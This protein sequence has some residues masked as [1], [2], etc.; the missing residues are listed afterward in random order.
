M[1]VI[2]VGL[3]TWDVDDAAL[4]ASLKYVQIC[5][6]S[7]FAVGLLSVNDSRRSNPT[8]GEEI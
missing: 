2:K 7:P 4:L 6:R 5:P 1:K 3:A 8:K